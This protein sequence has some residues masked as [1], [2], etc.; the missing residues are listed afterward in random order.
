MIDWIAKYII[1]RLHDFGCGLNDVYLSSICQDCRTAQLQCTG[2]SFQ[3]AILIDDR[4]RT[5]YIQGIV[6]HHCTY[7]NNN[8]VGIF[9]D[10]IVVS[11]R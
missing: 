9:V 11:N 6:D 7:L 5:G 1:K 3:V 4:R 10:H 2:I 8:T